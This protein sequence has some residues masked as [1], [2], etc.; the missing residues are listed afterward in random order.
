MNEPR[1]QAEK[2][3]LLT[4]AECADRIGLTVRG[5]RLYESRGLISPRRTAKSWRL[6]GAAEISRLHEILAL[7]RAQVLH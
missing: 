2:D 6:Y 7:K 5:L 1:N 4:A 3:V